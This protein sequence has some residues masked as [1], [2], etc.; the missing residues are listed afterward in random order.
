MATKALHRAGS[1]M[2]YNIAEWIFV[3]TAQVILT[4]R[5]CFGTFF[6]FWS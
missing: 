5:E 1:F 3:K 4:R 2:D 6:N